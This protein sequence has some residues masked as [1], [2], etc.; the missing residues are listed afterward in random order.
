MSYWVTINLWNPKYS[1]WGAEHHNCSPVLILPSGEKS[2][3]PGGIVPGQ[4]PKSY[5][6]VCAQVCLSAVF[7]LGTGTHCSTG[8]SEHSIRLTISLTGRSPCSGWAQPVWQICS[9]NLG[10]K[11]HRQ[12]SMWPQEL[13]VEIYLATYQR[14]TASWRRRKKIIKETKL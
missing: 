10:T 3:L 9:T 14:I 6:V 4:V 13:T 7:D 2:F 5:P 11:S 12:R 1:L 8:W